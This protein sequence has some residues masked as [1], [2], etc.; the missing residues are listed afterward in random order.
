MDSPDLSQPVD[1]SSFCPG[2][3][4]G[5]CCGRIQKVGPPQRSI[6]NSRLF[7]EA[8]NQCSWNCECWRMGAEPVQ[9]SGKWKELVPRGQGNKVRWTARGDVH[10]IAPATTVNRIA[11]NQDP[12]ASEPPLDGIWAPPFSGNFPILLRSWWP[13]APPLKCDPSSCMTSCSVS[14]VEEVWLAWTV[15]GL[16][17]VVAVVGAVVEVVLE[18]FW[19]RVDGAGV[20]G[21]GSRT[22]GGIR[23]EK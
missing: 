20:V 1:F 13:V 21:G 11:D 12:R 8:A 10:S 16:M 7:P 15:V 6:Y 9:S 18:E 22:R 23:G 5:E 2:H 19:A 14:W 17:V 3:R 4:Q